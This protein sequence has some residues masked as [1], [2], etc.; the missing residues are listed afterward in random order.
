MRATN[1]RLL[2]VVLM[3]VGVGG[4][5]ASP[6][7]AEPK[8]HKIAICHV[9]PGNPENAHV[10]NIDQHAWENGH[11][12]H[13]AHDSD[14]VVD[15]DNQCGTDDATTTTTTTTTTTPRPT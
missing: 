12:P 10:I 13:N 2:T 3:A 4:V 15:A 14:F 8:D 11:A 9:P 1:I 7:L 5:L 6:A